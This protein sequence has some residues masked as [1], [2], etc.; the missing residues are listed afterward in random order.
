MEEVVNV[1]KELTRI[2]IVEIIIAVSV[3]IVC[4]VFSSSIAQGIIRICKNK[5]KE[6][7]YIRTSAFY[8]PLS[9]LIKIFGIYILILLLK[10]TFSIQADIMYL[11][12]KIVIIISTISVAKSL[13]R[14]F[15]ADTAIAQKILQNSKKEIKETMANFLLKTIRMI[16]YIVSTIIVLTT[17][18]IN[19]NSIIAGLGIGSVLITLSAQ[20]TAKNL[21]GCL[22]IFL[23]R[24]FEL[25]DR[26]ICD[27]YEGI[28]EDITFRSTRIRTKDNSIANVPNALITNSI[29][30]NVSKIKRRIYNT[31]LSFAST[32]STAK[33]KELKTV[34]EQK[35]RTQTEYIYIATIKIHTEVL[36]ISNIN[37]QITCELKVVKDDKY[38]AAKDDINYIIAD[39]LKSQGIMI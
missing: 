29:I 22:M 36:T 30:T 6:A 19:V 15:S 34:I 24:P 20:D 35:L 9:I 8:K 2:Q 39:T 1:L 33:L 16:I 23:D 11:I 3:F 37:M 28:V 25:G 7:K 18:G 38:L 12:N 31:T 4:I 10:H 17:I 32:I 14:S 27:K 5:E 21:F 26:I 13:L